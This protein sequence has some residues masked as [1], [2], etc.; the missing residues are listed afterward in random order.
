MT[1]FGRAD[2]AFCTDHHGAIRGR[3]VGADT[4]AGGPPRVRLIYHFPVYA[5]RNVNDTEPDSMVA[6]MSKAALEDSDQRT[7]R[8][9]RALSW[10]LQSLSDDVELEPFLEGIVDAL[11]TTRHDRTSYDEPIRRLMQNGEAQLLQRVDQFIWCSQ[12]RTLTPET[13]TRRQLIALKCLWAMATIPAKDSTLLLVD[14]RDPIELEPLRLDHLHFSLC[15]GDYRKTALSPVVHEHEVSAHAVL[16]LNALLRALHTVEKT[17]TF[18]KDALRSSWEENP[19]L[20]TYTS[21]HLVPLYILEPLRALVDSPSWN[22]PH[23]PK[24]G[25]YQAPPPWKL[26]TDISPLENCITKNLPEHSLPFA[27]CLDE[28]DSLH[29]KLIHMGHEHFLDF[30]VYAARLG[31]PPYQFHETKYLLSSWFAKYE[32]VPVPA[33]K[34]AKYSDAFKTVM[35]YQCRVHASYQP[36]VDIIL[37]TLLQCLSDFQKSSPD[38]NVTLPNNLSRYLSQPY[39]DRF[40]SYVLQNC[41]KSWLC[42]CLTMELTTKPPYGRSESAQEILRA[43]WEVAATM[44]SPARTPR[45]PFSGHTPSRCM[46]EAL[47]EI[48]DQP[49]TISLVPLLQTTIVNDGFNPL[50]DIQDGSRLSN[51]QMH[52]VVLARFIHQA[53]TFHSPPYRMQETMSIITGFKPPFDFEVLNS[54]CPSQQLNFAKGWKTALERDS[55]KEFH[56]TMVEAIATCPLLQMYWDRVYTEVVEVEVRNRSRSWLSGSRNALSGSSQMANRSVT[57]VT[58]IASTRP[59]REIGNNGDIQWLGICLPTFPPPLV[60]IGYHSAEK[61]TN[62]TRNLEFELATELEPQ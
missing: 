10:T 30:I 19:P 60:A 22:D 35:D 13:L 32:V 57:S 21:C 52:V 39:F 12:S 50:P 43:M 27:E 48:P 18:L 46:L 55:P 15:A 51:F 4:G 25:V 45:L 53:S 41:D 7:H 37:A 9:Y 40:E 49:E 38:S 29:P 56:V 28:L 23:L 14:Q 61:L 62:Y 44:G 36:H 17:V 26:M 11:A 47:H 1:R 2:S 54:V 58:S 33:E 34:T 24:F 16:R 42:S 59:C 5:C 3:A 31:S 6:A 8:D 20:L